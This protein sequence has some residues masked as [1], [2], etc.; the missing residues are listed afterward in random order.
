MSD[1]IVS[2]A[3]L[4]LGSMTLEEILVKLAEINKIINK[5]DKVALVYF[6]ES[7]V[8]NDCKS[9][10]ISLEEIYKIVNQYD[11]TILN[12]FN[13]L[14]KKYNLTL[15][16]VKHEIIPNFDIKKCDHNHITVRLGKYEIDDIDI[17]LT[18]LLERMNQF[19]DDPLTW[20]SCQYN[21]FGWA[22]IT[23]M[24]SYFEKNDPN[25]KNTI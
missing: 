24:Y 10:N 7:T 1:K 3:D 21:D 6:N 4:E 11:K 13:C 15:E 5:S 8:L 23:F 16:E 19:E 22:I 20:M 17:D 14:M 25:S 12:H 2:L 9:G 18:P